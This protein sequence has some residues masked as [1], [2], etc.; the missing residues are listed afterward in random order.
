MRGYDVVADTSQKNLRTRNSAASSTV[1]VLPHLAVSATLAPL[2][3]C[4]A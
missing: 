2:P 3:A 1:A 4:L